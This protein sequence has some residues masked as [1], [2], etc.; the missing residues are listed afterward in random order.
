MIQLFKLFKLFILFTLF[1]LNIYCFNC[2]YCL[3][4]LNCLYYLYHLYCLYCLKCLNCLIHSYCT[5][6]DKVCNGKFEVKKHITN[7]MWLHTDRQT[8]QITGTGL[9]KVRARAKILQC[10]VYLCRGYKLNEE[11]SKGLSILW[12]EEFVILQY[13]IVL[14]NLFFNAIYCS[15]LPS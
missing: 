11:L 10:G 4:C 1:I 3:C 5:R 14:V 8:F 7:N 12:L 6:C 9:T 15:V 13:M 2:L